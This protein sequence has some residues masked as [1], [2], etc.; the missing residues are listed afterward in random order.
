MGGGT[1]RFDKQLNLLFDTEKWAEK[2]IKTLF[3]EFITFR[4]L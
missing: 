4:S 2:E 1:N 3:T